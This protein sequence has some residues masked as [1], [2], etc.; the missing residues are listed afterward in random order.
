[1]NAALK[2]LTTLLVIWAAAYWIVG[3]LK[4]GIEGWVLLGFSVLYSAAAAIYQAKPQE[5]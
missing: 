5:R 4:H 3:M 2:P 1:M